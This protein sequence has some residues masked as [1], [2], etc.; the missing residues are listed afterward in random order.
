M[1]SIATH[2]ATQKERREREKAEVSTLPGLRRAVRLEEGADLSRAWCIRFIYRYM[3][4]GYEKIRC[5][6]FG[7]F[8]KS[9]KDWQS[10]CSSK[11]SDE[12]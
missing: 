9:E 12:P 3:A 6:R 4:R 2:P 1:L 7:G 8:C 10:G 5:S 11:S